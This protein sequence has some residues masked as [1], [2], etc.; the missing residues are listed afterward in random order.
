MKSISK[1]NLDGRRVPGVGAILGMAG[2][3]AGAK[4]AEHALFEDTKHLFEE[5]RADTAR[6]KREAETNREIK[7]VQLEDSAHKD[8]GTGPA[9]PPADKDFLND[10][11]DEQLLQLHGIKDAVRGMVGN[12]HPDTFERL[13]KNK[14]LDDATKD[15]M[16]SEREIYL[17]SPNGVAGIQVMKPEVVVKLPAS[18][19]THANV[20]PRLNAAQL[21]RIDPDNLDPT[22]RNTIANHIRTQMTTNTPLGNQFRV[23]MTSSSAVGNRWRAYV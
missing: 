3:S 2:I 22:R 1:T 10:L 11:S 20:L 5:G 14:D 7:V 21:G 6:K 23:L 8:S 9:M 16:K 19:L 15:T 18:V 17:T 4:P 13:M 12:L